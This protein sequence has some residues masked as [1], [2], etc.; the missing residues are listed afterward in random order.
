VAESA[1]PLFAQ[2]TEP[3]AVVHEEVGVGIREGVGEFTEGGDRA[4]G[5]ED[6]VGHDRDPPITVFRCE[7]ARGGGVEM[8]VGVH[9]EPG[10]PGRIHQARVGPLIQQ[11][12]PAVLGEPLGRHEVGGVPVGGEYGALKAEELSQLTLKGGVLVGV[13]GGPAGGGGAQSVLIKGLVGR[14]EDDRIVG[15]AEIVAAGQG[16]EASILKRDG[17]GAHPVEGGGGGIGKI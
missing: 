7:G 10:A 6:A 1:P 3:V 12:H 14:A 16:D 5:R 4:V 17:V 2:D 13:P 15:Q 8:R 11:S 9:F